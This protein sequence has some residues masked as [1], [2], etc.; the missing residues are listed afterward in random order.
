M[1]NGFHVISFEYIGGLDSYFIHRYIII[2]YR[3][4][5]FKYKIH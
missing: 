4:G 1:K 3:S 2:N 5:T